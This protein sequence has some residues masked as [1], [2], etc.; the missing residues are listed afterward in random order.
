MSYG[1][2][3]D[4]GKG[5]YYSIPGMHQEA[6]A[7]L[8]ALREFRTPEIKKTRRPIYFFSHDVG[9]TIVKACFF[10]YPHRCSSTDLLEEAVMRLL[11]QKSHHW[12]GNMIW[13]AK[14]LTQTIIKLNDAFLR[15]QLLT[16]ANLINVVSNLTLYPALQIFP[17]SISTMG[18]PSERVVEMDEPNDDLVVAEEDGDHPVN[19]IADT[20]WFVGNLT[21]LQH[22]ALRKLTNQASPVLPFRKVDP[23]WQHPELIELQKRKETL[24]MH[25]RCS[26]GTEEVTETAS[27]FLHRN[28]SS[29]FHPLLYMKFDTHDV[30][31]N[32][33]DAM[34]RTF[35]ARLVCSRL[36]T[37]DFVSDILDVHTIL[38][39]LHNRT[40]LGMLQ[41]VRDQKDFQAG[42]YVLG[43]LDECDE[44][45]IWFL[46]ELRNILLKSEVCF[47]IL[48]TTTKGT[49][50]DKSIASALSEF[51]QE[52]VKSIEYCP[53]EPIPFPVETKTSKLTGGCVGSGLHQDIHCILSGCAGDHDLCEVVVEW[54]GSDTEQISR[55]RRLLDKPV[56]PTLVFAEILEGITP[57]LRPWSKFLLAWLLVCY[58]PLKY[59]EL[60]RISDIIWQ[61]LGWSASTQPALRDILHSFHGLITSVNGE[62]Q[63]RHPKTREWLK[64]RHFISD[65]ETWYYTAENGCHETVLQTCIVY[66]Q[67]AARNSEDT[68]HSIPYV[69]EFWPKH[70]QLAK[71]SEMQLLNL[72]ETELFFQFWANSLFSL[73]NIIPKPP[74]AHVMPLPVAAYL[75]L[76]R[77]V[78]ALLNRNQD[79]AELRGQALVEACR[80]GKIAT[81]RLLMRSYSGTLGFDDEDLH[82]AAKVV[83]N[84]DNDE[85]VRAFDEMEA[86]GQRSEEQVSN[87]LDWLTIPMY[88]A[89]ESGMDDVVARLLQLGVDPNP[90]EGLTPMSRTFIYTA[91]ANS[92][93]SCARLLLDAGAS[94]AT[95]NA[96]GFTA[97]HVASVRGSPASVKFLL[98]N[99]ADIIE[100]HQYESQ[101]N[102]NTALN[103]AVLSGSF[104]TLEAILSHEDGI[105][106]LVNDPHVDPVIQ[107]VTEDNKEC[108]KLL[109]RHGFSPDVVNTADETALI[110]AI[111]DGRIEICKLLLDH[112]A[113][114]DLTP[115]NANT[116]LIQAISEGD[117]NIVKLLIERGATIDKCEAPP[118]VGWSRTPLSIAADWSKPEIFKYL[119]K[120]GADPN[121]RDSD[122]IPVIGAAI[123]VGHTGMVKWLM[124]ASAEV[125]V[126]YFESKSTPLHEATAYPEMVRLLIEYGADINRVDDVSRT[127]LNLAVSENHLA[128]V[129]ILLQESKTKPDLGTATI[130]WDLRMVI[131]AGYIGV[132]EAL[133]EA[134]VDVNNVNDDGET[135]M[136]SA[137]KNN[138]HPDMVRK[139]LEYNPDLEL[140]DSKENTA[141]HHIN[142][143]TNLETVRLIVNAGGKLNV[144]NSKEE[145]PLFHAIRA[146]LDD[147]F[148]YMLRKEPALLSGAATL[149]KHS[150]TPLHE[151]CR[152]GTLSMVRSLIEHQMD[153]NS[154]QDIG[155]NG[156]PLIA[157][158]LREDAASSGLSSEI[159]A[160][161]LVNGAD[162]TIPAG[163]FRCPL[164]SACLSC[165]PDAIKLLLNPDDSTLY[166]DSLSRRPVHLSCYNSL[167][168]LNILDLPDSDFSATDVVGR[169]PLHYAVMRGDVELAQAVLER[170]KRAGVDVNVKDDD[171]WTPLLW[172]ARTSPIWNHQRVDPDLITGMVAFLL[173]NGSDVNARGHGIDKDWTARD[174]AYYHHSDE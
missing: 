108:L 60:R 68:A 27:F 14:N 117:L 64:G 46:S 57:D 92:H 163:L 154:C 169:V 156:T 87:P 82:E 89:A 16:Q 5:R 28:K 47:K 164:I 7:L 174:V 80:T 109:L 39:T 48:I 136:V 159:I 71:T 37:G 62:I 96:D 70:L 9:G 168:V 52:H 67:Y 44:S 51:S 119:L 100:K 50:G 32:N 65:E 160:L 147:V 144:S 149:S 76:T 59:R 24:L 110:T 129:Q 41:Y 103:L 137:I 78:E 90:R 83:G 113:D 74:P 97:L 146:Q 23:D 66:I 140:R 4:I 40:L 34:I 151:A 10:G 98:E 165:T 77:V 130:Q 45:S 123:S 138:A 86:E 36:G 30:R 170:S 158:T 69:F 171:G 118:D 73:P 141:L 115:T 166:Q 120:R 20:D 35:L 114:P 150:G 63:F 161:L 124:E 81:I 152:A 173:E 104:G 122:D 18:I 107:A 127:A 54:L 88:R 143:T 58:R 13:Y 61:Y 132:V 25:I 2:H 172:A 167:D 21:D 148:S 43:C 102:H 99:G 105:K 8:E 155:I 133:L 125:N 17:L 12:S 91:L 126:S 135:L 38:G 53:E 121:S 3:T 84:S 72:F 139:I 22:A 93:V 15:T 79:Q 101:I 29:E 6:A 31:F 75:G 162:P 145:T 33:C 157:A 1:Y 26:S 112:G 49:L 85:A 142:H 128:T 106:C 11:A 134:G 111:E 94:L 56:T 19:G 153:V 42:V 131:G 55:T 95:K 116:P